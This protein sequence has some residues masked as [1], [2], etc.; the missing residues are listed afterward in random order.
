MVEG[1]LSITAPRHP[2]LISAELKALRKAGPELGDD[3]AAMGK[4]EEALAA[5]QASVKSQEDILAGIDDISNGLKAQKSMR[6]GAKTTKARQGADTTVTQADIAFSDNIAA[7]KK[8]LKD[9]AEDIAEYTA[10]AKFH[11]ETSNA[12]AARAKTPIPAGTEAARKAYTESRAELTKLLGETP[13]AQS[14]AKV[15][16]GTPEETLSFAQAG[17]KHYQATKD[18]ATLTGD[19]AALR[20]VESAIKELDKHVSQSLT[21]EMLEATKH[22]D[23]GSTLN[24]MG[25]A[26]TGADALMDLGP[27]ENVA[28]VATVLALLRAGKGKLASRA[29][30]GKGSGMVRSM[31]AAGAAGTARQA[32]K[33]SGKLR[34]GARGALGMAGYKLGDT[35][36]GKVWNHASLFQASGRATSAVTQAVQRMIN[37]TVKASMGGT[38]AKATLK[39]L[40]FRE[41]AEAESKKKEADLAS[42]FK[43]KSEQLIKY[44]SNP[45]QLAQLAYENTADLRAAHSTLGDK[46]EVG[47]GRAAQ[48][49]YERLPKDPGNQHVMGVS[50]WRPSDLQIQQFANV[51][52]GVLDPMGAFDGI[53]NGEVSI[54]AAQAFRAVYPETFAKLQ[55][56]VAKNAPELVEK[57]DFNTQNRLSV[58]MGVPVNSMNTPEYRKF[59]LEHYTQ[60]QTAAQDAS[61]NV[62]AN[63]LLQGTPTQAQQLQKRGQK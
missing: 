15:L 40:K 46:V 57:L 54:Q 2:D 38:G 19:R 51:V 7:A 34:G 30:G 26:V 28:K 43:A 32:V 25:G 3:A 12:I 24:V 50:T 47:S 61:K 42:L 41:E 60:A 4:Y 8:L 37:G 31:F 55:V 45:Q 52:A 14:M 58:F 13:S 18:L 5:H 44:A 21:P 49:M 63:A 20:R 56:E 36:F 22:M 1:R 33:G 48:Y 10:A 29:A 11:L 53:T 9:P 16:N 27:L 6:K 17:A 39:A 62:D 23:L 35:A 59:I